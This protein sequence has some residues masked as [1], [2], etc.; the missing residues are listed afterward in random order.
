MEWWK[1][2]DVFKEWIVNERPQLDTYGDTT[3]RVVTSEGSDQEP[4]SRS[5]DTGLSSLR[6]QDQG[7]IG[8]WAVID[9]QC[10]FEN[11]QHKLH[12]KINLRI[13]LTTTHDAWSV[14]E[15]RTFCRTLTLTKSATVRTL[16]SESFP[17]PVTE[18]P[19]SLHSKSLWIMGPSSES[20]PAPRQGCGENRMM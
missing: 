8:S 6:W 7:R 5:R 14:T 15:M 19:W 16:R 9:S 20:S 11:K 12:F 13:S 1:E 18:R 2:S 3:E 17:G 10:L 4:H